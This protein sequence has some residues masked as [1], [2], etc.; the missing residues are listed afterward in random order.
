[1]FLYRYD[2]IVLIFFLNSS[3]TS[4]I[5]FYKSITL[6]IESADTITRIIIAKYNLITF[7]GWTCRQS[8]AVNFLRIL[9]FQKEIT[10][11]L[12]LHAQPTDTLPRTQSS[13]D[14]HGAH[15]GHVGP[16]RGPCW[17]HERCYRGLPAS[18]SSIIPSLG[19]PGMRAAGMIQI[20]EAT[21]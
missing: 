14:Q 19:Y 13:R 17:P 3:C 1:M 15:L 9:I 8:T 20:H 6:H 16:R 10:W 12:R 4:T 11:D 7:L 2:F 18:L 21:Y 5:T